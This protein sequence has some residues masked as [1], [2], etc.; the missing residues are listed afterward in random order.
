MEK[1]DQCVIAVK[2]FRQ[3]VIIAYH[4]HQQQ[5]KQG[6]PRRRRHSLSTRGTT[7]E[8]NLVKVKWR[9]GVCVT[10]PWRQRILLTLDTVS[11]ADDHLLI[12]DA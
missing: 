9:V 8:A 2:Q 5:Q 10:K 7:F 1:G 4:R 11:S 12:W 6:R 3:T